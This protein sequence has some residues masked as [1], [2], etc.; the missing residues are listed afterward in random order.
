MKKVYEG[1][2]KDVYELENGNYELKFKD[3]VTGKDG[4]LIQAKIK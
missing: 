2:T 3:T 4:V 1:K